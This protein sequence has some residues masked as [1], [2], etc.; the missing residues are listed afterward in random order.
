MKF[1]V[2]ITGYILMLKL[3]LTYSVKFRR[4]QLLKSGDL[5][6]IFRMVD[7]ALYKTAHNCEISQLLNVDCAHLFIYFS[8]FTL[9]AYNRSQATTHFVVNLPKLQIKAKFSRECGY[10]SVLC[11]SVLAIFWRQYN[12]FPLMGIQR[13]QTYTG[14]LRHIIGFNNVRAICWKIKLRSRTSISMEFHAPC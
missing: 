5:Q 9:F 13:F 1:N 4:A 2:I 10:E 3:V 6:S 7:T 12:D 8:D 11:S 14:R